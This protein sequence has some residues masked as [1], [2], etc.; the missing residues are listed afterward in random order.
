MY[1]PAAF[2]PTV[3]CAYS[4]TTLL[5]LLNSATLYSVIAA[6]TEVSRYVSQINLFGKCDVQFFFQLLQVLPIDSYSDSSS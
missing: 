5:H 1:D 3:C 2:L 4:L 6:T